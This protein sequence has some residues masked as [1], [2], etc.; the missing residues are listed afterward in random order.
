MIAAMLTWLRRLVRR[1][2]YDLRGGFLVR[3]FAMA[4]ALGALG[5]LLPYVEER[6]R[7]LDAWASMVPI[8]ALRD[9]A[10]AQALLGVISCPVLLNVLPLTALR[11]GA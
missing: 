8:A 1:A 9:P 2:A 6:W 3:P 7:W 4:I 11:S 5:V 10:T